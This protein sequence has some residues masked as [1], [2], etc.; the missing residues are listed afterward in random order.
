MKI[1]VL[2]RNS[3]GTDIEVSCLEQLGEVTYYSNTVTVEEVRERIKDADIIVANKAPLR[4]ESLKDAPNVKQICEF[5]TGYDNIDINYC[6]VRGIRVCNVVD[7]STA[8][9]AQHTFTLAL[10]L[11][12][13]LPHYDQYVKSGAYS[14]QDRF[15]NFD[16]P[17]NELD[18]KTWGIVGMGN[19]G[20][21]VAKIA[22]AFGCRVIFYSITGK[23]TCTEYAQVDK[24]TL[25]KE[26][27]ILS[28][29]CPLS[30]LSR[31]F[32]DADAFKKMKKS[33]VLINV[34]RGPVVNNTDLYH[35]LINGEIM[36]AGLDVIEKEPLEIDNPLSLLKDSNQLII[37]PHLAW[38]SVEA[39][40]RCV[41]GVY[42][43]IQAFLR[44]E[45]RNVVN[46]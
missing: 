37:T 39:R 43:N 21:R 22:S 24:D 30:D 3:V 25:L 33:A 42:K 15:S 26:S 45:S 40:T 11:S 13:K 1:V 46:P 7:Y 28:L 18:G 36:A 32:I 12:Q 23:S 38:A 31:N 10:A 35:A 27:D 34:A 9:V 17:F 5:A 14:A 2:E 41:E 29:H 19:I 44:G 8:M 4:E 20:K 6:R 16:L